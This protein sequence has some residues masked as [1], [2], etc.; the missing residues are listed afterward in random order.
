MISSVS[1]SRAYEAGM[2]GMDNAKNNS[3]VSPRIS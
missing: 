3:M 2:T 1:N